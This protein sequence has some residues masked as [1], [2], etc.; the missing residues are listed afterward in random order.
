VALGNLA[1]RALVA[2]VAAPVLILILYYRRP[3]A[4]WALVLAAS[5]LAM[6]E[7]LAM[8][9]K[10]PEQARDRKSVV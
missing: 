2:V 6:N 7:L 4:T 1:Q 8:A 5:L 3:E 9:M 10:E